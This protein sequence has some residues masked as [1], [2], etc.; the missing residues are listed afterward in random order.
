MDEDLAPLG[1][2]FNTLYFSRFAHS[3]DETRRLIGTRDTL[4]GL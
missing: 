3:Y 1:R 4:T 2:T